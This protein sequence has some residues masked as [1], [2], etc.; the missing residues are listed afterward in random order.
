M[1]T[2]HGDIDNAFNE[3]YRNLNKMR[4]IVPIKTAC[5]HGSPLSKFDNRLIWQKYDYHKLGIKGEPYLDVNYN[6]VLYLTDTGRR[7][8]GDSVNIRDKTEVR[9]WKVEGHRDLEMK[10]Q[11]DNYSEN[12]S[13]FSKDE[14]LL[15][16]TAY[17]LQPPAPFPHF[18]ST[19]DI[20]KAVEE[21]QL[22]DKI[23]MTF[24]PQRWT[25]KPFPWLKELVWQNVKNVGKYFLT[26]VRSDR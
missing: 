3:F 19:F 7:W 10:R 8:D 17:I 20:I 12:S 2:S 5:M 4:Q 23:M 24:H 15:P 11:S 1:D 13:N 14:V 6:E 18:H 26:K 21:N 16:P 25:D 9:R 22:P